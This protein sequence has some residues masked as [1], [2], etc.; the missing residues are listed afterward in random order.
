MNFSKFSKIR[1]KKKH[2]HTHKILIMEIFPSLAVAESELNLQDIV[3]E[4]TNSSAVIKEEDASLLKACKNSNSKINLLIDTLNMSMKSNLTSN[5]ASEHHGS[6]LSAAETL[7]KIKQSAHLT[8]ND[9]SLS[10]TS[11][12][13][14]NVNGTEDFDEPKSNLS[15]EFN[16][17]KNV[18][19]EQDLDDE[20]DQVTS[21]IMRDR[22]STR[23]STNSSTPL[24][25]HN[26]S[27]DEEE[28]LVLKEL[29]N[30]ESDNGT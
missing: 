22:E 8:S 12:E 13:D 27:I 18:D 5:D 1:F 9:N 30:N 25:L 20:Y 14:A 19:D 15:Y 21:K 2:R 17:E 11:D 6:T 16:S 24:S 10:N 3:R 4:A 28:Q 29:Q 26:E 7:L 23:L